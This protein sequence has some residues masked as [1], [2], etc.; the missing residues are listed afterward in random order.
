MSKAHALYLAIKGPEI[1]NVK[2]F[3]QKTKGLINVKKKNIEKQICNTATT[4]NQ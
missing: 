1:T 2:Q 4:Y 3:K